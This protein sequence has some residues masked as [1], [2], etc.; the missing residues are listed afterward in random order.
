MGVG[1]NSCDREQA[2]WRQSVFLMVDW[3]GKVNVEVGCVPG[4]DASVFKWVV[5]WAW[6]DI[7]WD[8]ESHGCA[9]RVVGRTQ[10][11]PWWLVGCSTPV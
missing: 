4:S 5:D 8:R 6:Y 1:L 7:I 3:P 10:A 9:G 2:M 11:M